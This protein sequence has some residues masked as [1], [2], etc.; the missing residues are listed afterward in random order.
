ML[1]HSVGK[2]FFRTGI[3]GL[4]PQIHGAFV[5]AERQ[6]GG[7]F[8][9]GL[10]LLHFHAPN[11]GEWLAH[12]DFRLSRGAYRARPELAAYLGAATPADRKRFYDAV[13]DASPDTLDRLSQL[14]LLRQ[15]DLGL[16]AKVARL[17]AKRQ[18]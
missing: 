9:P 3:P 14:S 8:E 2:C 5:G 13:Q 4:R 7:P 10:V 17:L 6:P 16:R 18:A 15:H 12:L 11:P 1:G